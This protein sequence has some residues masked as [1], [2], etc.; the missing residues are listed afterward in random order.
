MKK[1]MVAVLSALILLGCQSTGSGVDLG[2]YHKLAEDGDVKAMTTLGIEY[3][4]SGSYE[5]AYNWFKKSLKAGDS[6]ALNNLGVMYRDGLY[7]DRNLEVAY[8]LFLTT[9]MTG[10]GD[11]GTQSRAAN[12]LKGIFSQ[13]SD[14]EIQNALCV[15]PKYIFHYLDE[16]G[17]VSE[18]PKSVLPSSK[19]R[20]FKDLDWWMESE[21]AR[22]SPDCPEPWNV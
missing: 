3:Y 19:V 21:K 13:L 18:I 9:H 16:D 17:N 15:T 7:V 2:K 12:N 20:R 8:L 11:A 6:D 22:M 14:S 10:I 4:K 1:Q 5:L